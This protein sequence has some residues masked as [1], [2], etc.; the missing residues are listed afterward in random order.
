MEIGQKIELTITDVAAGGAGVGRYE[1]LAVFVPGTCA[2]E[3]ILARVTRIKSGCAFAD[4]LS[5]T[6]PSPMRRADFCPSAGLCGGCDLAH[7]DYS[8]QL[9]IKRK[10]V[11]DALARIGGFF[12]VPVSETLPA[13]RPERYRNK[14]VFPLGRDKKGKASGGF[15]ASGT[16]DV[17]PL[18]DCRQGDSAASLWLS[19]ILAYLNEM[20]ISIYDEHTRRGLARRVFVRLAEGTKEAMVV[21][22]A[23]A[24]RL[25]KPEKLIGRL[26]KVKTDYKIKSILL[27]IHKEPNNLLLGKTSRVLYGRDYIVD[28]LGDLQFHISPH[29]F[30]QIN[31]PQTKNLYETAL[32]LAYLTGTETVLDLYCGIG[33]ISLFAAKKAAHI[34]GVEIVPQAIQD[35]KENAARNGIKNAEF[36]TG[37]AE[38]VAPRLAGSGKTPQVVILDPPRK[39]AEQAA[40]SAIIQMNPERIVYVSCNPATLARDAKFL[41]ENGYTLQKAIPADMFPNTSHCEVICALHRQPRSDIKS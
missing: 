40:L 21:L 39:G 9:A 38:E 34:I 41:C 15:Y 28:T 24:D 37:S 3:Q 32:E 31:A 25:P 33:T 29:S 6:K 26:L 11:A 1:G 12:D 36:I 7:M 4:L 13:P 27:N 16:H 18:S 23:T 8:E 5:V 35:A 30:Y 14:M 22:T 19:E 20:N 10:I 17:I 2:N